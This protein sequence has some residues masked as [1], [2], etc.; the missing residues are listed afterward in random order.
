[1]DTKVLYAHIGVDYTPFYGVLRFTAIIDLH[2][3]YAVGWSVSNA[4]SAEW[5]AQV[6]EDAIAKY[7]C[8]EMPSA[9]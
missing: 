2:S 1:M 8:K 5:C 3:R 6:L 7:G 9:W 4:M